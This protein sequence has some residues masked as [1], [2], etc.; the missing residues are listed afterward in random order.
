MDGDRCRVEQFGRE[1]RR[2][3]HPARQSGDRAWQ[4][5]VPGFQKRLHQ[6]QHRVFRDERGT[7]FRRAVETVDDDVAGAVGGGAREPDQRGTGA[8]LALVAVVCADHR[9]TE[10]WEICR[11][12]ELRRQPTGFVRRDRER[13]A[14]LRGRRHAEVVPA[15]EFD[16]GLRE[17]AGLVALVLVVERAI[18]RPDVE[19]RRAPFGAGATMRGD[20]RGPGR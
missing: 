20:E 13:A 17:V 11:E 1:R 15:G 19:H 12:R 7:R 2:G 8:P 18:T 6:G 4:P 14:D 9:C 5:P 10:A 16:S 3:D